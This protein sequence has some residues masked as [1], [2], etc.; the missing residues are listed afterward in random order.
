MPPEIKRPVA[1]AP[2]LP[3]IAAALKELKQTVATIALFHALIDGLVVFSLSYLILILVNS[4]W[5]WAFVPF[6]LYIAW[7]IPRSIR[8]AKLHYIE[9]RLPFLKDQL[10]T[11][12]DYINQARENEVVRQLHMEVIQKMRDI[13]N[14]VFVGFGTLSTRLVATVV[15][16][17]LIIFAG[18]RDVHFL[19]IRDT[20]A[21]V[22]RAF[23]PLPHYEIDESLL[24]F[25][26]NGS[27]EEALGDELRFAEAF[28]A[29]KNDKLVT[30]AEAKRLSKAFAKEA[31]KS[32]SVAFDLI[33]ARHAALVG[34]RARQQAN[35]GRTAA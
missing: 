12:A 1:R 28:Q 5:Y 27:L 13:Y 20:A 10:I 29:L 22:K 4:E 11:S 15:L 35:T 8:R 9:S 21:Q 14:S 16:S 25:E 24:G 26:E 31:A 3:P 6:G 17:F 23:K 30:H 34:S 19:D 7:H 2:S 32:K 18:A 33:W